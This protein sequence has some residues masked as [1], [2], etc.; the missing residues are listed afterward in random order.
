M[1]DEVVGIDVGGTR[2][3]SVLLTRSGDV[4]A[5]DTRP[6]PADAS[7]RLGPALADIVTSLVERGGGESGGPGEARGP[8]E[9]RGPGGPG[10]VRPARVGIGVPG[11]VD[12]QRQ[13]G[14]RSANLGWHDLDLQRAFGEHLSLP[15]VVGHDVRCGLLA[16][17]RL[18]AAQG[19]PEV[20]FV[21]LG[22]GIAAAQLVG[23]RLW[24]G[25]P[26]AGEIGHVVVDPDGDPCACGLR[27]CLET[28]ASAGAIGRRWSALAGRTGD[29][30]EV[31]RLV[32]AGDQQ[33]ISLWHNAIEALAAVISPVVAA[34][35]TQLVLVGGGLVR[36]GDLLLD[37]L[38]EAVHARLAPAMRPAVAP[39]SLG[40]RAGSLGAALLSLE[41]GGVA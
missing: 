8:G 6:T 26:W 5:E 36:A 34:N 7:V 9:V 24:H 27:G 37:P 13:V 14:V 10:E 32:A 12:E 39:A 11:I 18:G 28:V 3:K 21:P 30:A 20:L 31:A 17:A 35:G 16:E 15:F 38:R 29:A 33:A 40:D 1:T 2:I 41:A 4:L 25:R 22:T 19:C 23:G